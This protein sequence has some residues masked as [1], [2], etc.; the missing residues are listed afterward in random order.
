MNELVIPEDLR[1]LYDFMDPGPGLS[2][3]SG[4]TVRELIERIARLESATRLAREA[5]AGLV[6]FCRE[7]GMVGESQWE[8]AWLSAEAALA[9]LDAALKP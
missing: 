6:P 8:M 1:W 2:S 7:R 5:I 4:K 3:A 9:A